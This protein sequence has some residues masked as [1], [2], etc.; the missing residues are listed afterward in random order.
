MELSIVST[1][2]RSAPYLEEFYRRGCAAA[3]SL[4]SDFEIVLVND[5]S[6]DDSLERARALVAADHRVRVV[7]LSRNFGHHKAIMTGLSY[8]RGER[9]FLLDSDLEEE[10]ELLSRFSREMEG[11]D[12]DVVY[13][14]QLERKGGWFERL[15]G[16]LFYSVFNRVSS[17]PIPRNLVTARLM[18]RRY[19]DSLLQ[20]RERELCLSGVWA[21]TGFVQV[22][23]SIRK[24]SKP[25]STYTLARKVNNLVDAITSFSA[26]PLV[27]MFYTGLAIVLLSS[28][29]GTYLI[30][31]RILFGALLSGWPSLIVSIWFLGGFTIFCLGII[32]VYLSR[33]F[34]E[35]KQRPYTIVRE[36]YERSAPGSQPAEHETVP[37][38]TSRAR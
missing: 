15:S 37:R 22:P 20:H 6:P 5:C 7:D 23:V 25:H 24:H 8:A 1:L 2:Y 3:E 28:A 9:V 10:P 4:T 38:V 11:A 19:V 31:R 27:W 35:V 29:A 14:V 26:K 30:V 12:A 18:S 34:T 21:L 17:V 33:I 13:G 16:D 36:L 32:G